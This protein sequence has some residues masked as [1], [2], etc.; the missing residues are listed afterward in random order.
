MMP[1]DIAW[2]STLE[3]HLLLSSRCIGWALPHMYREHYGRI[4]AISSVAAATGGILRPHYAA[5]KAGLEALVKSVARRGGHCGVT[6]NCV[7][8]GWIDTASCSSEIRECSDQIARLP[9]PRPGRSE[10][11][12]ALVA[13]LASDAAGYITGQVIRIDGGRVIA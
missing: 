10:E 2:S 4:I 9:V 6:A 3:G 5:A 8:P 11:V 1:T 12:A 13:F 7:A